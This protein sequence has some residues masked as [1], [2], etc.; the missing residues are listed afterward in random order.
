[1]PGPD[2]APQAHKHGTEGAGILT[3]LTETNG[4][5]ELS[6]SVTTIAPGE[7]VGYLPYELLF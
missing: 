7:T 2:G 1:V 6:E 4:F 3:S 5:A